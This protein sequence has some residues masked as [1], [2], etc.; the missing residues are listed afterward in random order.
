MIGEYYRAEHE[1]QVLFLGDCEVYENFSPVT[2]YEKHGITSYIRGGPN[3][4]VWQSYYLLEDTLRV[5]TP[6]IV[7]FNVLAMKDAVPASEAYNR[8]NLDGM[9]WSRA[10]FDAIEA[11]KTEVDSTL[12]YLFPLL[13]YHDRWD[14]LSAEDFRY[15]FRRDLVTHNGYYM[16]VDVKPADIV[17]KAPRLRDY[18]LPDSNYRWLDRMREL[19]ESRGAELVLVKAP[20]IY[21]F[22]YPEWDDQI[23]DYAEEH[24]LLYTNLLARSGEIGLDF[25]T[26]TYDGGLH[27]NKSG[28]EKSADWFGAVLKDRYDLADRRSDVRARETWDI[29]RMDYERMAIR[30][31]RDMEA[32]GKVLT[33]TYE[34]TRGE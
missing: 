9:R 25:E 7:V 24:H 2:L 22:W 28:A 27:L 14:E 18:S 29:I 32:Y 10:K 3:Q 5:E 20:T 23:Q 4:L 17:P 33:F 31:M 12:S 19:C 11:S 34:R 15:F 1:N 30:Q 8:L 16:R 21:P 13:R 6:E 26:D